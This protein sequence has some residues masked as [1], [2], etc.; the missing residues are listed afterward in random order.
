MNDPYGVFINSHSTLSLNRFN[1]R[2]RGRHERRQDEIL[3][4]LSS[5]SEDEFYNCHKGIYQ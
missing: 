1:E 3:M 2:K 4:N 5:E